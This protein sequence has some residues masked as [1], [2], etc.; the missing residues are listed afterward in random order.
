MKAA[1]VTFEE[2]APMIQMPPPK[3]KKPIDDDSMEPWIELI[4]GGRFYYAKPVYDIGAIA[5][6]L[7]MQCR[8][9]GHCRKF[10]SVA[11]HSVLVSRIM[12][13]QGLGD[14][15]EGLLHD[16]VESVLSDVARPAKILLKD[17]KAL[18]RALDIAMRKQFVLP[19]TMSEGCMKA[20][21]IALLIEAKELMPNKG[22]NFTGMSDEIVLAAKK[23]TY[24]VAAWTP[25]NAR[26]R[27]MT[28]MHDIRRRTRGLR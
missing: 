3:A 18:D 17:Y 12:E 19:E 8:F 25:E 1:K 14:P 15:M 6:S 13:D 10:Y 28:R 7:S 24:I 2:Q 4:T 5:H 20:D 23:A 21:G 27:F 11:E 22:E 16:A 26:E 9:T